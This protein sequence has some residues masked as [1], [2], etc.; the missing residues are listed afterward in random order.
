MGNDRFEIKLGS[1]LLGMIAFFAMMPVVG[2]TLGRLLVPLVVFLIPLY[3]AWGAFYGKLN[4]KR[5]MLLSVV[6]CWFVF[7][8][9]LN[10][11]GLSQFAKS[12]AGFIVCMLPFMVRSD[13]LYARRPVFLGFAAGLLCVFAIG[14][15][16]LL[17]SLTALPRPQEY[18]PFP[19]WSLGGTYEMAGINRVRALCGEPSGLGRQMVFS[20]AILT[21]YSPQSKVAHIFKI[22]ASIVCV[23]FLL[24]TF[25]MAGLL[26]FVAFLMTYYWK[27]IFSFPEG[28]KYIAGAALGATSLVVVLFVSDDLSIER[29]YGEYASRIERGITDVRNGRISSSTGMRIQSVVAPIIYVKD[30]GL[31]GVFL[32]EGYANQEYWVYT[33]FAFDARSGLSS[34]ILYNIFSVIFISTGILGLVLYLCLILSFSKPKSLSVVTMLI[35]FHFST[36]LLLYFDM[37][38]LLSLVTGFAGFFQTN[39]N[40]NVPIRRIA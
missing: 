10:G 30:Q 22:F 12:L 39:R 13:E 35:L 11:H 8:A 3:F 6:V 1:W 16:D 34:G 25:S 23:M 4:R 5:C 38:I 24:L 26:L 31:K 29:V 33:N 20:F 9:M 32:G 17:G 15:L 7:T 19:G 28:L 36:G 14:S 40:I 27:R 18:L 21:F 2:L 37:W